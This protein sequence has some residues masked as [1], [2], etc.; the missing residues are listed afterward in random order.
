MA[1]L[2]LGQSIVDSLTGSDPRIADI[3][4]ALNGYYYDEY[5]VPDLDA[6]RQVNVTIDFPVYSTATAEVLLVNA[7]TNAVL[8]STFFSGF[9]KSFDFTTFPALNYKIQVIGRNFGDY[10][11]SLTDSGK[12]TSIISSD[13]VVFDK[14]ARPQSQIGT[15]S[16]S[17]AYAPLA[18]GFSGINLIDVALAADGQ[19]YG[20]SSEGNG[21]YTLQQIDPT[22]DGGYTGKRTAGTTAS[23]K[24]QIKSLGL[25]K[26]FQGNPIVRNGINSLELGGNKQLYAIG[27]DSFYEINVNTNVATLL[28][29]TSNSAGFVSSGDLLY[30][31]SNQRFLITALDTST[32]DALWQIPATTEGGLSAENIA[33]ATKIGQ[34]GFVGVQ[35]I[36]IDNGQ[37]VGFSSG[38]SEITQKNFNNRIEINGLTGTGKLDIAISTINGLT[39]NRVTGSSTIFGGNTPSIINTPSTVTDTI[40]ANRPFI[41]NSYKV[42]FDNNVVTLLGNI[43]SNTGL[44]SD[45]SRSPGLP[46]KSTIDLSN[47]TGTALK[48]DI[49]TKGDAAYTNNI[50]FYVVEDALLGTIK[51]ANGSLL[52]PGDTGYALEAVKNAVLQAGKIDS[53]VNRDDLV[54]GKIYAPVVV[55]QGSFNDF[56]TKN[57]TNGGGINDIHAYFNYVS[58]NSD[59]VDHFRSLGNNT[60]GVED[61]YGGGDRDFN[62]IVATVNTRTV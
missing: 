55:A 1:E 23:D 24:K 36:N 17:G 3:P 53:K 45:G 19:F 16:A 59:K 28:G 10:T 20:L 18:S 9:K 51:L 34:I 62:D 42:N 11:L 2:K 29:N 50:G 46:G 41:D 44:V 21:T 37:I 43:S 32:S 26:D 35:G 30:D 60:F 61:T 48:T 56:V 39:L 52:N 54:G 27:G 31:A 40:T 12:A 22:A 4:D 47:Y 8:S 58:G 13:R 25:L 7:D 49:T 15:V 33:K 14:G 5:T 57:P 6:F 38:F